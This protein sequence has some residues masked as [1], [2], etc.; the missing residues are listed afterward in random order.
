LSLRIP[1]LVAPAFPPVTVDRRLV[2]L[3]ALAAVALVCLV[4]NRPTG[5]L[6]A[7]LSLGLVAW[8]GRPSR[9]P[10]PDTAGPIQQAHDDVLALALD[11]LPDPVLVV[12]A[13]AEAASDRGRHRVRYAN[14]AAVNL[15]R[16][17]SRGA[18][19][20]AAIRDPDVLEAVETALISRSPQS[21]GYETG[22]AHPRFWRAWAAPL[23]RDGEG[24]MA[25]V[26]LRDE[27][28]TRRVEV[29]RVD[30]LAN[31]S[32]ELRTPLASLT[33]FIETLRGHARDDAEARDKFLGIMSTQ[34][35]RMGRLVGDLL[36]LSRIELNEH[37]PPH[38]V[39]D[40]ASV[41]A[42]VTDASA[43][44][45]AGRDVRLIVH[46]SAGGCAVVGE[47][48]QLI[49]VVQN[50]ID[51]ALKYSPPGGQVDI[52]LACD[53]SA[54]DARAWRLSPSAA[55]M[56]LLTPDADETARYAL[57]AVQDA[58]PGM[59]R[60][61]L[62]RLTERFYRVEGQKSGDR[63]GTGLGLAIVKHIVNRHRGGLTVES[64]IGEGSA[65]HAY[66]PLAEDSAPKS[67]TL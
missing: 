15:M 18:V 46:P 33:G 55:R 39:V 5:A 66:F 61:R 44:L 41:V 20:T 30:F 42:D 8:I 7:L 27:T 62:P 63:M 35:D 47:R 65:F 13:S 32:H 48:D 64:A 36:S 45:S 60:D 6:V 43:L 57:V 4:L 29:M 24:V 23:G 10:E 53:L 67:P 9:D 56:P 21:I 52:R 51:N 34:A 16:I 50:L 37:V 11:A 3:A 1:V 54:R 25:L 17:P 59:A 22:G 40:L 58:G 19:L 12:E 49:Q 31:A 28:D 26:R 2:A 38:D 14:P